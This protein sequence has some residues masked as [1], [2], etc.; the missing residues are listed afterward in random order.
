[1]NAGK[2][3]LPALMALSLMWGSAY[4]FLKVSRVDLPPMLLAALRSSIALPLLAIVCVHRREFIMNA[5]ILRDMLIVGTLNGWLPNCLAA[6]AI[7]N[8]SS[9][10]AGILQSTT[11][12]ITGVTAALLLKNERLSATTVLSLVAGFIGV[13]LVILSGFNPNT[14]GDF[15]GYLLILGVSASFGCGTVY[16]RWAKPKPAAL[17]T[18]GQLLFASIAAFTLSL[19]LGE[20]WPSE[21][22]SEALLSV[23]LLGIFS[24][25]L[26]AILFLI[27]ISKHQAVKVGAASFLQP[28]WAV[29]L[30]YFILNEI[31]QPVQLFGTT[32]IIISVIMITLEPDISSLFRPMRHAVRTLRRSR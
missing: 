6:L 22:G 7:S 20:T 4:I 13:I 12:I 27:I 25:A 9:A 17:I 24:T 18:S 31:V 3:L 1:M 10:E 30:G 8:I 2:K 21:I 28:I 14:M 5:K 15:S 26:P 32:I 23:L 16:A 29:V 11:P 19:F